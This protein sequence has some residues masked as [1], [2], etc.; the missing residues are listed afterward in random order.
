MIVL[1]CALGVQAFLRQERLLELVEAAAKPFADPERDS[2]SQYLRRPCSS[3][4]V[5][6][7]APPPHSDL[8]G[9]SRQAL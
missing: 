7:R 6:V 3:L 4:Y 8:D 1:G 2:Q 5:H 9:G